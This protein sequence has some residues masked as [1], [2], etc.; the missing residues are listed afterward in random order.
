MLTKKNVG[1]SSG[2]GSD[3]ILVCFVLCEVS[4]FPAH[5]EV[6]RT[7]KDGFGDAVAMT[8]CLSSQLQLIAVGRILGVTL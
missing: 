1:R 7:R 8:D 2:S 3:P 6:D 5:V 4:R